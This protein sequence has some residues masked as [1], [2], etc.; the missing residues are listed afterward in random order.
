M[1]LDK[2]LF[3]FFKFFSGN[4][5]NR[6]GDLYLKIGNKEDAVIN[7]RKGVDVFRKDNFLRNALA[8]QPD[9]ALAGLSLVVAS[10]ERPSGELQSAARRTRVRLLYRALR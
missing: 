7:F 6:L 5:H 3:S 10:Q 1:S 9:G 4:L 2:L 8:L